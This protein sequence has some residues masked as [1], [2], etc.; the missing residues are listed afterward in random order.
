MSGFN[1]KISS[2][3]EI[4]VELDETFNIFELERAFARA[5][6][7]SRDGICSLSVDVSSIGSKQVYDALIRGLEQREDDPECAVFVR[8][9]IRHICPLSWQMAILTERA[10]LMGIEKKEVFEKALNE[11]SPRENKPLIET[12]KRCLS[13]MELVD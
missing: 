6:L 12:L 4:N 7:K 13:V 8:S 3:K 11:L 5:Y 2:G 9:A 1:V 10:S